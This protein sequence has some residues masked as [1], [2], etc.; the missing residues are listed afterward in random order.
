VRT[1]WCCPRDRQATQRARQGRCLKRGPGPCVPD[2]ANTSDTHA[3]SNFGRKKAATGASALLFHPYSSSFETFCWLPIRPKICPIYASEVL[4]RSGASDPGCGRRKEAV[5]DL[6]D[7]I[8]GGC[9]HEQR[10]DARGDDARHE[11]RDYCTCSPYHGMSPYPYPFFSPG[12][13]RISLS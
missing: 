9:G 11:Q 5:P 7:R 12:R 13:P 10:N 8:H 4:A 1:D 3:G 6:G 2:L